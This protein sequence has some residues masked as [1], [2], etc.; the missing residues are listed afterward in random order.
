[1]EMVEKWEIR[2]EAVG[3]DGGVFRWR[4]QMGVSEKA[5]E[6]RLRER[7][8]KDA[9]AHRF[10]GS[11]CGFGLARFLQLRATRAGA[12]SCRSDTIGKRTPETPALYI[13]SLS[14]PSMILSSLHMHA[15]MVV[16]ASNAPNATST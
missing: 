6:G 5:R 9:S 2:I 7:R 10:R 11:S 3:W 15:S 8:S 1:M 12:L 14:V 13:F 4:A 16:T